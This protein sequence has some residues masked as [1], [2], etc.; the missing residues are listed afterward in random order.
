MR[1]RWLLLV[2]IAGLIGSALYEQGAPSW[3]VYVIRHIVYEV[4]R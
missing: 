2:V 4:G 3:A 1:G